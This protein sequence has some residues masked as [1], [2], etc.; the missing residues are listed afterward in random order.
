MIATFGLWQFTFF[1]L[2]RTL[3]ALPIPTTRAE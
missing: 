3:G 2:R 1:S